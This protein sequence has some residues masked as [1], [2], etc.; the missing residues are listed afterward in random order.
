MP[1]TPTPWVVRGEGRTLCVTDEAAA[2]VIDRFHLPKDRPYEEHL[3]NAEHIVRCVNLFDALVAACEKSLRLLTGRL[4]LAEIDDS[5]K[6]HRYALL[7]LVARA[8]E[9]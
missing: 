9:S 7:G 2:Y 3:A 8:R 4:D 1:H 6:R 5:E